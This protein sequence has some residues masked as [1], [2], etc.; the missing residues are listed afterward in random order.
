MRRQHVLALLAFLA[1]LAAAPSWNDTTCDAT[2][3]L[4][5]GF[6]ESS[7]ASVDPAVLIDPT[8]LPLPLGPAA[9]SRFLRAPLASEVV[10]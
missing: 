10:P 6:T 3:P 2:T 1:L 9:R 4:P 7:T 8:L 5:A